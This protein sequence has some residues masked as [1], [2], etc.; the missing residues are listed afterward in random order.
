MTAWAPLQFCRKYFVL[1]SETLS[2]WYF[3]LFLRLC[4]LGMVIIPIAAW[5]PRLFKVSTKIVFSL[6]TIQGDQL[7]MAVFFWYLEKS[8]LFIVHMYSIIH[9]RSHINKSKYILLQLANSLNKSIL[10]TRY[11]KNWTMLNWPPCIY[12]KKDVSV[13]SFYTKIIIYSCLKVFCRA[14]FQSLR[15]E[16]NYKFYGTDKGLFWDSQTTNWGQFEDSWG[17]P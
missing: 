5:I 9:W 17:Q 10:L 6:R 2:V 14:P 15:P 12:I 16:F 8:D 13:P 1:T 11:Q 4:G 7:N 3:G